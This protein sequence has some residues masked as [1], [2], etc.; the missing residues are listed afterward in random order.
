MPR[1]LAMISDF[2]K[3]FLTAPVVE[4]I[5]FAIFTG[6]TIALVSP[7]YTQSDDHNFLDTFAAYSIYFMWAVVFL[8]YLYQRL[9][10][11]LMWD[12][13]MVILIL[14]SGDILFFGAYTHGKRAV[15][16]TDVKID[17]K[18]HQRW[19]FFFGLVRISA[20]IFCL[21]KSSSGF[22]ERTFASLR[23]PKKSA[24]KS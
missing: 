18:D 8:P 15:F 6:F 2:M 11:Q 10:V 19:F 4:R 1:A 21:V 24:K 7:F 13:A 5:G 17:T 9:T 20:I 14:F 22:A 23:S 3:G 12:V 16:N